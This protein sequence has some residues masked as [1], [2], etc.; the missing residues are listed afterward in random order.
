[1]FTIAHDPLERLHELTVA[2]VMS[3]NVIVI[4]ASATMDEAAQVLEEVEA[5][6]APVVNC[7]GACI[8]I[9]SNTDF[10]KFEVSRCDDGDCSHVWLDALNGDYLPWNS[11][12]RFMSR[13]LLAVRPTT[14][15]LEAAELMCAEH[16]HRC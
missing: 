5:S 3:R 11:V 4:P 2:D 7:A 14:P 13:S 9:L 10:L 15:L 12:Q 8:G 1:M 16:I 6:G